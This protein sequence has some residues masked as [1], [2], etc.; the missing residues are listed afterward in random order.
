METESLLQAITNWQQFLLHDPLPEQL[1]EVLPVFLKKRSQTFIE[2]VPYSFADKQNQELNNWYW[3]SEGQNVLRL[4]CDALWKQMATHAQKAQPAH[5]ARHAMY[6]VPS[7]ALAYIHAEQVEGWERVGVLGA[8]LHDHGRWPEER[9]YG[10]PLQSQL[11]AQISFVL[12]QEWLEPFDMP[13]PVKQHILLS[14]LRHTSGADASDP[15]PLKITVSADRDQLY[16]PEF[17]LR[18]VH[19]IEKKN[20]DFGSFFGENQARSVLDKIHHMALHRLPGPLFSRSEYVDALWRQTVQFLMLAYGHDAQWTYSFISALKAHPQH[21]PLIYTSTDVDDWLETARA[22]AS[23]HAHTH[24]TLA[25]EID[26]LLSAPNIAPEENYRQ[27]V[28]NKMHYSPE[29]DKQRSMAAALAWT[30]QS[31]LALDAVEAKELQLM[32]GVFTDDLLLTTML[33]KIG[34]LSA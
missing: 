6:K 11:H 25:D 7:A 2:T 16:G 8:L 28:F 29:S 5:D 34:S 32:A 33:V 26:I 27:R 13:I 14:A 17:V 15:M 10:E 19:H 9:I 1:T 3:S 18:I 4:A 20:G 31:R 12:G 23:S 30:T 22:F 21:T 24:R